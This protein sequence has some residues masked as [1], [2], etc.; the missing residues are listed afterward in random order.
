ML[1]DSLQGEAQPQPSSGCPLEGQL[2]LASSSFGLCSPGML[3]ACWRNKARKHGFLPTSGLVTRDRLLGRVSLH[4]EALLGRRV[5]AA[6]FLETDAA[7]GEEELTSKSPRTELSLPTDGSVF[8][9]RH[10]YDWRHAQEWAEPRTPDEDPGPV[11][12][13][14]GVC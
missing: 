10:L 3:G 8:P 6:V 1:L 12:I 7:A 4:P 13:G 14:A 2:C 9:C 5:W 11:G